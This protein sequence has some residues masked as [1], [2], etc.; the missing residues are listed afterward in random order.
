MALQLWASRSLAEA[1]WH[2][3][4]DTLFLVSCVRV[5]LCAVFG[6]IFQEDELQHTC[7][8]TGPIVFFSFDIGSR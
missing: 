7:Q 2:I 4:P 5:R 3:F 6:T 8:I 1:R